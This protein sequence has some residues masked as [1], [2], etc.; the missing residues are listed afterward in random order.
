MNYFSSLAHWGFLCIRDVERRGNKITVLKR[1]LPSGSAQSIIWIPWRFQSSDYI[2]HYSPP[3][4]EKLNT[5]QEIKPA[6]YNKIWLG[7][8]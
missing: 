4:K 1:L 8:S 7:T 6:S 5:N 2:Q 3:L